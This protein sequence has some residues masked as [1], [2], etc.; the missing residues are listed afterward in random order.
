MG[1]E[2]TIF[3]MTTYSGRFGSGCGIGDSLSYGIHIYSMHTYSMRRHTYNYMCIHTYWIY[4]M[5]VHR[6]CVD[7]VVRVGDCRYDGPD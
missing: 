2:Y 4:T 7:L 3:D 6:D 1:S 5:Y